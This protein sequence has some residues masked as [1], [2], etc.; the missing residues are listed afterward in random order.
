[1]PEQRF[2]EMIQSLKSHIPHMRK[3]AEYLDE[4]AEVSVRLTEA[5]AKVF[6]PQALITIPVLK[7]A[8]TL[9]TKN[10][11]QLLDIMEQAVNLLEKDMGLSSPTPPPANSPPKN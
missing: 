8:M 1:M 11:K 9:F 2:I 7:L 6:S 5:L 10:W 4:H 3:L